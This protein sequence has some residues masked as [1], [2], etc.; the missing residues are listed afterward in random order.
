LQLAGFDQHQRAD[1]GDGL[2]HRGDA[3]D[4]VRLH[5]LAGLDVAQADAG[6]LRDLI[7]SRDEHDG[8]GDLASLDAAGNICAGTFQT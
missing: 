7:M 5:R 4:R 3:K 1:T 6:E 2:G 8:P